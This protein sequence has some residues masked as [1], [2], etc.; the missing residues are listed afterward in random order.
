MYRIQLFSLFFIPVYLVLQASMAFSQEK[1]SGNGWAVLVGINEYTAPDSRIDLKY[2]DNDAKELYESLRSLGFR[3]D[4]IFCLTT[5]AVEEMP[6]KKNIM[7]YIQLIAAMADTGD[8]VVVFLCGLGV[9][10]EG[11]QYFCPADVYFNEQVYRGSL[12][13]NNTAYIDGD[14]IYLVIED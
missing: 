4:R 12:Y 11:E 2:C 5:S 8:T 9:N 6:V 13:D 10:I 3:E 1:P 7:R 14:T